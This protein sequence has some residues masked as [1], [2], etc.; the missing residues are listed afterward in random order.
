MFARNEG[1]LNMN[2]RI[3]TL[4]GKFNLKDRV[5]EGTPGEVADQKWYEIENILKNE[6]DKTKTYIRNAL[7]TD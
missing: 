2:S 7:N 3:E 6:R 5:F 1:G 4:L